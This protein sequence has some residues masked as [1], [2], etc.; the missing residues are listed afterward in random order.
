MSNFKNDLKKCET[1]K[2]VFNVVE[3]YYDINQHMGTFS[4]NMVKS[5]IPDIVKLLNLKEKK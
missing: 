5:K 3:Q 2:Q 4:G 1:L